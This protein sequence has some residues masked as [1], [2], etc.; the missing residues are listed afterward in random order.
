M[1]NH[2]RIYYKAHD[3]PIHQDTFVASEINGVRAND[4]H[5]IMSRK[6]GGDPSGGKDRIE[7]LMAL[8]RSQHLIYGDKPQFMVWLFQVHKQHLQIHG[9]DCDYDWIDEQI[10]KYRNG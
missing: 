1:K 8:T 9:I 4:I 2:T 5:H 10:E 6:I 7:N 3:Y